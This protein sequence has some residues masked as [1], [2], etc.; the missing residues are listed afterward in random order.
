MCSSLTNNCHYTSA[1]SDLMLAISY[2]FN[3]YKFTSLQFTKE[4]VQEESQESLIWD[5]HM[6][7]EYTKSIHYPTGLQNMAST[8]SQ[9]H[10][11]HGTGLLKHTD[12]RYNIF[13]DQVP[14]SSANQ[15]LRLFKHIYRAANHTNCSTYTCKQVFTDFNIGIKH[16]KPY[17]SAALDE[18]GFS[19][20]LEE[21]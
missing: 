18:Q 5:G 8:Q 3:S 10:L 17:L 20:T 4:S 21:K 19:S 13:H 15:L 1:Y 7:M 16:L 12:C 9:S 14:V 11:Q 2:K 6:R